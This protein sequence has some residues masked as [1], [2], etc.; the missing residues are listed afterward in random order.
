MFDVVPPPRLCQPAL[1]V[2]GGVPLRA[3]NER[4]AIMSRVMAFMS[5]SLD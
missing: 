3:S 1:V 5:F 2:R 4:F